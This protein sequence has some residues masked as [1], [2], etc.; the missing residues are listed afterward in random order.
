MKYKDE[1]ASS[2]MVKTIA[3]PSCMYV[4]KRGLPSVGRNL[5]ETPGP[6][7]IKCYTQFGAGSGGQPNK[8][9]Y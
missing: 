3:K 6:G 7:Y 2:T 1:R 4:G 9:Y 8:N 5:Q